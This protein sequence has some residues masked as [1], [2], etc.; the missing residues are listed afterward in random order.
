MLLGAK[1]ERLANAKRQI[2]TLEL[3]KMYLMK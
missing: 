2:R 1:R 3:K